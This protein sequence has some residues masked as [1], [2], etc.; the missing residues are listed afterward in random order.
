MPLNRRDGS[1]FGT[2][3]A[4][5]PL[6]ADLDPDDFEI[7]NLLA[8]LISFEMEAEEHDLNVESERRALKDFIA[9]AAHDLRQPLTVLQGR[10]QLLSRRAHREVGGTKLQADI[11]AVVEQTQRTIQLSDLLL[12]VA[13]IEA[14]DIEIDKAKFDLIALGKRIIKDA[15]ATSPNHTILFTAPDTL[16]LHAD[17]RRLGRV[18]SNLLDNATKY[19]PPNSGPIVLKLQMPSSEEGA[20]TALLTISDSGPG[21]SDED[22][23]K[24]FNR[25]YRSGGTEAQNVNGSGLGL[26]I[27]RQIVNAHGGSLWAERSTGGG[28]TV[29]LKLPLA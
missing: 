19:A 13:R 5:D 24:I 2:L 21:V 15:R 14:G 16:S 23:D 17:E 20:G 8:Q 12:D 28:L 7:F 6:P 9:I 29:H 27:A 26:Y 22:L 1:Y 18:L 25:R 4:L 10:V 3:C 11:D